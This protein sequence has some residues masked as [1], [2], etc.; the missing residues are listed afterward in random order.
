MCLKANYVT[1]W[2]CMNCVTLN[3]YFN[4]VI[5]IIIIIVVVVVVVV[6][7]VNISLL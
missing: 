6:V 3:M 2:I 7:V 1:L 5:T 4:T